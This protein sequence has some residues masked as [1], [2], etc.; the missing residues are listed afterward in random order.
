MGFMFT[1]YLFLRDKETHQEWGRGREK[2]R[3]RDRQTERENLKQ[4]LG[5]ELSAQRPMW[6]SYPQTARS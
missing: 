2:E 1:F 3:E 6:G 5:S 4:S